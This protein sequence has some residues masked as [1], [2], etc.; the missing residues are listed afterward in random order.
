M[1]LLGVHRFKEMNIKRDIEINPCEESWEKMDSAGSGRNCGVC[2]TKVYDLTNSSDN[3]IE[4]FKGKGHC[5]LLTAE[6]VDNQRFI[7][8]LKRFAVAA[9]FAF[10]STLFTFSYAQNI[11]VETIELKD[12]CNVTGVLKNKKN[13]N[14]LVGQR[15]RFDIDGEQFS[16][17]TD[18]GGK[19]QIYLPNNPRVSMSTFNSS[20]RIHFSTKKKQS[21]NIGVTRFPIR[22]I[23]MGYF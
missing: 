3:E 9:M 14:V 4:K 12:S 18:E 20:K 11:N 10:G 19:F 13:G 7:H 21:K 1:D 8:P 5:V 6:Q 2:Q 17:V 22:K 23:R 15:V 16:T